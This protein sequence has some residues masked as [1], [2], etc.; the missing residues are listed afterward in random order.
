MLKRRHMLSAL[1]LPFVMQPILPAMAT[2]RGAALSF[3]NSTINAILEV[4]VASK[5]RPETTAALRQIIET[6]SAFAQLARFASGEYWKIMSEDQ[7][8]RFT[9]ALLRYTAHVYAGYFRAYAGTVEDLRAYVALT[10]AE[11]LGPRGILVKSEIRP[12]NQIAITIDWLVSDRSGRIAVS[13]LVVGGISMA[14]TQRELITAMFKTRKGD[15]E[16]LI[17]DLRAGSEQTIR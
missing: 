6:R 3:V 12:V 7:R 14:I 17:A 4:I 5:P 15:A 1:L 10:G 2:E 9:E 8:A 11:D 13:D 16:R